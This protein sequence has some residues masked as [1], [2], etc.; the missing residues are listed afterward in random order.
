M[1]H[2]LSKLKLEI[3]NFPCRSG[4]MTLTSLVTLGLFGW[5][6][7]LPAEKT[8]GKGHITLQ[9]KPFAFSHLS[10][11]YRQR[12][13]QPLCFWPGPPTHSPVAGKLV[14][15]CKQAALFPHDI[16]LRIKPTWLKWPVVSMLLWPLHWSFLTIHSSKDTSISHAE[17]LL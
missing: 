17:I 13:G 15:K 3:L 5:P 14:P 1:G 12:P 10:L 16:L 2:D 6:P 7:V 9:F 4:E 11:N 8:P